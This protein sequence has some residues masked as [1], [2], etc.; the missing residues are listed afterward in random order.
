MTT[1]PNPPTTGDEFT[2]ELTGVTYRY[3]G[4]KWLAVSAPGNE[5][6]DA[7]TE[8][9]ADGETVQSSIQGEQTV[10]NL[11]LIHI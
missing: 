10:Q 1:I 6:L 2:N 4:E 3:D 9:V 8:R 11:S 5:A 7:L